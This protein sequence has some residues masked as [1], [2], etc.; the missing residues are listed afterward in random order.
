MATTRPITTRTV[1][2]AGRMRR[3][4]TLLA[5]SAVLVVATAT[6][7]A[8]KS[9][10]TTTKPHTTKLVQVGHGSFWTCNAKTTQLLVAVNTL[11]LHPGDTLNINFIV[12]NQAAAACNYVAPYAGVAP[13]PTA[14]ALQAGPCGS[15]GFE[16]LG[17]HRHNVWPGAQVSNCPALGY[18]Q[19]APGATV[20]GTGTWNQLKPNSTQR[21]APGHYTLAVEGHFTFPLIIASN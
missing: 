2:Q 11:T 5:L 21:I 6:A 13:G 19:L 1:G 16:I 12:R 4:A 3:V 9:T 15:I 20:S 14:T 7:A 17:A 10:T 18:A 8:A